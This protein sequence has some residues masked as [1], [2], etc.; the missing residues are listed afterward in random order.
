MTRQ[1]RITLSGFVATLFLASAASR[2]VAVE[3]ADYENYLRGATVGLPLGAAAPPGLYSGITTL[4]GVNSYAHGNQALPVPTDFPSVGVGVPLLWST[5]WNVFGANYSMSMVQ[6]FYVAYSWATNAGGPAF[7]PGQAAGISPEMA[8]TTFTPIALS[9]NLGQGWFF[10]AAFSFVAPDGSRYPTN[11]GVGGGPDLNP[12]YWSFEPGWA[13]S[14]LA[15][16]WVA[17]ANFLYVINT[18][19]KGTCCGLGSST[20]AAPGQG[21][22]TGNVLFVDASTAYKFGKWEIGPIAYAKFQTTVDVPGGGIPCTP[23]LCGFEQQINLGG[24]V[25]YDFGPVHL[26]VWAADDVLCRNANC[27][28]DVWTRWSFK[29]WGPEG[30]KPLVAKD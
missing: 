5:G 17:S 21:F 23:A 3:P 25:G 16:D 8:N 13:I 10:A 1:R 30:S 28:F 20:L 24:L 11:F 14:Y 4:F 29:I 12:D 7:G 26:Q 27:G 6:G 19:S 22:T 2:S 15:K 9:W 18:A